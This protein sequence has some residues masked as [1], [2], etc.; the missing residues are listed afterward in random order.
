MLRLSCREQT[1]HV[2]ALSSGAHCTGWGSPAWS[3]LHRLGL[4]CQ[5]HTAQVEALLHDRSTQHR[6]GRSC[7]E[8][9]FSPSR[10]P[11][12]VKARPGWSGTNMPGQSKDVVGGGP[13]RVGHQP[14]MGSAS[15]KRTYPCM[16]PQL[17]V[18]SQGRILTNLLT[19]LLTYMH[20]RPQ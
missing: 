9:R 16:F 17:H 19:Y 10:S 18:P 5:E 1:A 20:V 6:S 2:W 3:T 13:S 7:L 4:S 15:A 11:N 14:C 8:H 12:S